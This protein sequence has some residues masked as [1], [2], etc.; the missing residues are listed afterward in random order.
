MFVAMSA[1]PSRGEQ[2][3][4]NR[5]RLS[6]YEWAFADIKRAARVGLYRLAFVG[7]AA[8]FDA[9]SR[10]YKGKQWNGRDA[11]EAF[12]RR[13]MPQYANDV[14]ALYDGLR[15]ALLHEYGTREVLLTHEDTGEH[16]SKRPQ[17]RVIHLGSLIDDC[18]AAFQSFY[19]ELQSDAQ[20][21][22][23]VLGPAHGLLAPVDAGGAPSLSGSPVI[24][25]IRQ[26]GSRAPPTLTRTCSTSTTAGGT[27]I[28]RFA[29][30]KTPTEKPAGPKQRK[31]KN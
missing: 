9:V 8:W 12:I 16:W 29:R 17:G 11:L 19:G 15:N 26:V 30:F 25:G 10:L 23:T 1:Q 21:R 28:R 24:P 13:H 2:D 22:A 6:L 4:L 3:M 31:R 20:L 7:V 14:D 5:L 27:P 18:E